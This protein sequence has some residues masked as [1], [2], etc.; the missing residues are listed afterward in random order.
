MGE[1]SLFRVQKL[2]MAKVKLSVPE[3][4]KEAMDGR[5]QRWL[6]LEIKMPED[7]LSKK[8]NGFEGAE[9]TQEELDA[10]N[11]RLQSNIKK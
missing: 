11:S 3:Q 2:F 10:I 8:M 1:N 4:I 6:A 9:F 5:T 7:S